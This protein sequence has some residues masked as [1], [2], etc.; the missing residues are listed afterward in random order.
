MDIEALKPI[1]LDHLAN[2][3]PERM[4]VLAADVLQSPAIQEMFETY[5][6]GALMLR[7]LLRDPIDAPDSITVVATS[8]NVAFTDMAIAARFSLT[9][10]GEPTCMIT[11]IPDAIWSFASSF[12]TLDETF[13]PLLEFTDAALRLASHDGPEAVKQ[14]LS[15]SGNLQL[16]ERLSA[17]DWLLGDGEFVPL[18]G[19]IVVQEGIPLITLTK[20]LPGLDLGFLQ[21]PFVAF[22][23]G[24]ALRQLPDQAA[25]AVAQI[26]LRSAIAFQASSGTV[27]IPLSTTLFLYSR[28]AEFAANLTQVLN[29]GLEGLSSLANGVDFSEVLPSNLSISEQLTLSDLVFG[30][31]LRDRR[32]QSVRLTVESTQPWILVEDAISIE[33][34]L[35]KLRVDDVM[36]LKR[37]SL[38]ILGEIGLD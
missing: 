9:S 13:L 8:Y 5:L 36:T 29:S 18:T 23:I 38:A 25:T 12:P 3:D 27:E 10:D 22:E 30:V 35:L 32:L 6:E 19:D 2:T 24:T 33:K 21:L 37:T 16:T 26:T 15:F 34:L 4:P 11:A 20:R 14:G 1:I 31:N 28:E 17:I 7:E